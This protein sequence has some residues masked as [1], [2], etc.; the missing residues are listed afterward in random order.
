MEAGGRRVRDDAVMKS[1]C[2][3]IRRMEAAAKGVTFG[4]YRSSESVH[5]F[6]RKQKRG[7]RRQQILD[8]KSRSNAGSIQKK[9]GQ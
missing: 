3:S 7:R 5:P 1:G 2:Y 4:L 9:R 6:G 8:L